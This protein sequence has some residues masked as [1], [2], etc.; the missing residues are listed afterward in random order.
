MALFQFLSENFDLVYQVIVF[1]LAVAAFVVSLVRGHSI[2]KAVENFKEVDNLKYKTA[3]AARKSSAQH[4]QTFSEYAKD[5]VLNPG[6][7]ELEELEVPKNIQAKID[8]YLNT[9]LEAALER[10][11]P[12]VVAEDNTPVDYTAAAED[13]AVVGDAMDRA[14]EYREKFNLPDTMSYKEIYDFI[15]TQAAELKKKLGEM[16]KSKEVEENAQSSQ[17]QVEQKV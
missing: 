10:F 6:T 16:N 11:M 17:A 1:G 14:E 12:K 8:S 13:L 3:A 5:Y 2:K 15:G 9:S 4:S 7:N